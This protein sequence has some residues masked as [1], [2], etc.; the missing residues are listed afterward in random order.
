[1][2]RPMPPAFPLNPR[3]AYL[4]RQLPDGRVLDVIPLLFGRARLLLSRSLHDRGADAV[5]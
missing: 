5:W 1:M 2:T 3:G 4:T